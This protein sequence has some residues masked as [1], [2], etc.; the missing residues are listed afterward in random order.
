MNSSE[1]QHVLENEMLWKNANVN[2][3]A[4]QDIA[5]SH[6]GSD[7]HDCTRMDEGAYARVFLFTLK[8]GFQFVARIVLP[9]RES[10]KTQAEV[11]AMTLVRGTSIS[12]SIKE[13]YVITTF[14]YLYSIL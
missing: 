13:L 12:C 1:E 4:M 6:F 7:Y 11:A 5:S 9:V 2:M 8:N 10:V 3:T 14:I